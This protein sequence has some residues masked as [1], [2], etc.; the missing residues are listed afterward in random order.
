M[1]ATVQSKA[2]KK[3]KMFIKIP[4]MLIEL[5]LSTN[6][7]LLST[8]VYLLSNKNAIGCI[9]TS[10]NRISTN[11]VNATDPRCRHES[12][13]I[14]SL[15]LLSS[16]IVNNKSIVMCSEFISVPKYEDCL[17]IGTDVVAKNC[18]NL[19][20]SE[21]MI[22]LLSKH[23]CFEK[24]FLDIEVNDLENKGLTLKGFTRLTYAE[25]EKLFEE[26]K[27]I[28]NWCM[29]NVYL[30]I[31]SHI[32]KNIGVNQKFEQSFNEYFTSDNI[33]RGY[34]ISGPT[35]AKYVRALSDIGLVNIQKNDYG[36]NMYTIVGQEKWKPSDGQ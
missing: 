20:K 33:P 4:N 18:K 34:S 22:K 7:L 6:Q 24:A 23:P 9:Q 17:F 25:I 1:Y 36:A 30:M 3:E 27:G 29:L 19:E 32:Q 14:A 15:M 13:I 35:F 8:Y 5:G 16:D 31:K 2:A 10:V 12:D 21:Y 28:K 26:K 11:I